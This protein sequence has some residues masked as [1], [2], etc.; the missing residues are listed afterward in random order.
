MTT[1]HKILTLAV[2]CSVA[3]C[4]EPY[5][6]PEITSSARLLV[7]D[8]Y[9]QSGDGQARVR[10]SR[11]QGLT[12]TE[13]IEVETGAEV[14]LSE[15]GGAQ[16]RLWEQGN[17]EYASAGIDV[18]NFGS[19]QLSIRTK[20]GQR[21]ESEPVVV[22]PTPEIDSV[23]WRVEEGFGAGGSRVQGIQI[24]V[25]THDPE[26]NTFYYRWEYVQTWEFLSAYYSPFVWNGEEVVDRTDNI[27][28]CWA[29]DASSNILIANSKRLSQDVIREFPL[30]FVPDNN[31]R[32]K[33]KY[34]ILVKQYA[35]SR[36]GYEYWEKLQKNTES[37]G[38]IFDPLPSEI[39]G[40]LYNVANPSEPVIGYFS[41]YDVKEKRIFIM[42]SDFPNS[43][44]ENT[45]SFCSLDTVLM[46]RLPLYLNSSYL[47]VDAIYSEFPT[48]DGPEI[49]GYLMSYP[50]CVDCRYRGTNVKPDFWK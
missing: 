48:P 6:P 25:N 37:L 29:S 7:V 18:K 20:A 16:Y 28:R 9:L 36:E 44:F 21:Y 17:G 10:L 14:M 33:V 19:Y 41:A 1:Y 2:L 15:A 5:S 11:T 50:S 42:P 8:G 32:L 34:S 47:F 30:V 35:E 4:I 27:Y 13:A 3:G 45:Y 46:E 39:R 23:S 26:N 12:D 40:N 38:T 22:Q 24:Y 43:G 31:V 49:L